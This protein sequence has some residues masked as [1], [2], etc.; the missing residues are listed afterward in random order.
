M[1]RKTNRKK[2]CDKILR[3]YHKLCRAAYSALKDGLD[4]GNMIQESDYS[5]MGE[6][7]REEVQSLYL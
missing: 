4:G 3:A 7:E 5:N 1:S 2:Q 6:I